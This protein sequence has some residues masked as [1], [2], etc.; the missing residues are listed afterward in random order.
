MS[1]S[2]QFATTVWRGA[3]IPGTADTSLTSPTNQV[4]VLAAPGGTGGKIEEIVCEGVGTTVAGIVYIWIYDG[5]VYNLW[6]T[7]AIT[8]VTPSTTVVPFRLSKTYVN[9]LMLSTDQL[10]ASQSIAGNANLIK[11]HA[12]GGTF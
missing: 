7:F 6:D 8:A 5:S 11:V 9:L 12:Q 3:A 10:R 1:D 4:T 2:P